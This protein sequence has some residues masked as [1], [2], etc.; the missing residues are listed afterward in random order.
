M[1]NW[2]MG[3]SPS[4]EEADRLVRQLYT[5]LSQCQDRR[6]KILR[7]KAAFVTALL[8]FGS[9]DLATVASF[10]PI[11][12]LVPLAAIFFDLLIMG[13]D[14]KIRRIGK[15]F[16]ESGVCKAEV[17]WQLF[18]DANRANFYRWGIVMSTALAFLTAVF[19]LQLIRMG[20]PNERFLWPEIVW[21]GFLGAAYFVV[22]LLRR[23]SLGELA[24]PGN[25]R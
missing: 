1:K 20:T 14:F 5:E 18:V 11:L 4:V 22:N 17:R 25:S 9:L 15:F 2:E 7:N 24:G 21:F 6:Y 23:Q 19:L 3:D 16:R 13:E 8:G 12:Y 10:F